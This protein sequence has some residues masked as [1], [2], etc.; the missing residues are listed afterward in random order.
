MFSYGKGFTKQFKIVALLINRI[1]LA[2]N[3]GF[4]L[5]HMNVTGNWTEYFEPLILFIVKLILVSF[6]HSIPSPYNLSHANADLTSICTL[7]HNNIN[8]F[9]W[10]VHRGISDSH[11]LMHINAYLSNFH[12]VA[13]FFFFVFCN[14]FLIHH[15]I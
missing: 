9:R 14:F 11:M 10:L 4:V 12:T 1:N 7:C 2:L 8:S 3:Y 13:F 6:F 5:N 15:E